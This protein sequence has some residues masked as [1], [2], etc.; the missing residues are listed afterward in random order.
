MAAKKR[1]RDRVI[2]KMYFLF[3]E[4]LPYMLSPERP[5]TA[6]FNCFLFGGVLSLLVIYIFAGLPIP[7][8]VSPDKAIEVILY[9]LSMI[10]VP[11]ILLKMYWGQLNSNRDFELRERELDNKV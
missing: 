11:F 3:E 8:R 6:F 10:A 9:W 1:L 4:S 7:M 2:D 5:L